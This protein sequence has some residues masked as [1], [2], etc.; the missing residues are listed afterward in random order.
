M[1]IG[2]KIKTLRLER[3]MTQTELAGEHITRNMLSLIESGSAQPS[4]STITYISEQLGVP[5][6]YLLADEGGE[7]VYRKQ[8]GMPRIRKA[9]Q[10]GEYSLC[11][12]ICLDIAKGNTEDGEINLILAECCLGLAKEAFVKGRLHGACRLFEEACE[13]AEQTVYNTDRIK[14]EAGVYCA[15]MTGISQTLYSECESDEK[16]AMLSITDPFCRYALTLKA[17]E[18]DR[19]FFFAGDYA[20]GDDL[21]SRHVRAKIHIKNGD[22]ESARSELSALLNGDE[23]VCAAVMYDAFRELEHCCR[24]L[25]DFK[26]AYEYSSA[27]VQMLERLL[28]GI[29]G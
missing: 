28:E 6:G 27:K 12:E 22:L 25:G 8:M 18:N 16:N 11:R 5:A 17:L 23:S 21:L 2:T 9:L 26:G 3:S 24:E 13:Y 29:D 4:L 19:T 20:Q 14:A 15:Y 7:F 1:N 10:G